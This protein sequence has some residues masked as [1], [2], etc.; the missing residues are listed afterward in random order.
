M[1]TCGTIQGLIS[2]SLDGEAGPE[3]L[4]AV[5]RHLGICG[6]CRKEAARMDGLKTLVAK[7]LRGDPGPSPPPWFA[8][9]VA[10]RVRPPRRR[11]GLAV[12]VVALAVAGL[13]VAWFL[14]AQPPKS[15]LMSVYELKPV[16]PASVGQAALS[17]PPSVDHYFKE[18]AAE[19]SSALPIDS[20]GLFEYVGFHR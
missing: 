12:S 10:S 13:A 16:E 5:E 8:S 20:Q 6:A 4:E 14:V 2:A 11:W 1:T 19:A 9:R 7:G 17:T 15:Q 3:E 18:H